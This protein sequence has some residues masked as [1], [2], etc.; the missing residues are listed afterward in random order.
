MTVETTSFAEEYEGTGTK[1]PF[2]Y[3][4]PILAAA[5]LRVIRTSPTGVETTLTLGSNYTVT[6][7]RNQNGGNVL[8]TTVLPVG[9]KIAIQ[10]KMVYT[11]SVDI[12]NQAAY[13]PEVVEEALDRLTMCIQQLSNEMLT[14]LPSYSLELPTY[15]NND[16]A[17]AAG[18]LDGQLYKTSEGRVMVKFTPSVPTVS[19]AITPTTASLISGESMQLSATVLGTTNQAVT[20][21]VNGYDGGSSAVGTIT[22]EG[23]SVTYLSPAARSGT[24]TI[25]VTSDED[26][27][28]SASCPVTVVAVPVVSVGLTPGSVTM[29][30]NG[31]QD[32]TASVAGLTD[33]STVWKV[34]GVTDGDVTTG[35][36]TGTGLTREYTAPAT[37]GVHLIVVSSAVDTSKS[38]S[39]QVTVEEAEVVGPTSF[40]GF[41]SLATGGAGNATVHVTNLNSSGTGSFAAACASGN[42]IIV[43]D[44]GGTIALTSEP[45]IKSNTTVDGSTAPGAGITFTGRGIAI[46]QG[47]NNIILKSF[48]HRGGYNG[49][50]EED[51]ITIME[52][53]YNIVLDHLSLS[54]SYDENIGIWD[55]N[56]NITVQNCIVGDGHAS[57][58]RY[59]S[60]CSNYNQRVTYYHNLFHNVYYRSPAIGYDVSDTVAAPSVTAD[61]VNNVVWAYETRGTTVYHGGKA[62]V[63]GNYY[64][65]ENHPAESNRAVNV[66]TLGQ[67]YSTG[68]Y[69]LDGSGTSGNA[70]SPFTVEA[71]AQIS[72]S[73]AADALT[74][75]KANAGCR[76]GGLDAF[77]TAI[78]ADVTP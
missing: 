22:G 29:V 15:T 72:A 3:R 77:D 33:T 23:G 71:Y 45:T 46:R 57:G 39:A 52:D 68:N 51:N 24:F 50:G 78:M 34:D 40:Y 42:R 66:E 54:G 36:I 61:V 65:S 62:N 76:T 67:A 69:S 32:F 14:F 4:F 58:E 43:F 17:V 44:V 26:P 75:V 13:L 9:Y 47:A 73:S 18:L 7:A 5:D 1:G 56:R 19:I 28:K 41:G 53:C 63:V 70:G 49:T 64:Y 20:W 2:P 6:G 27:T 10:R 60:L 38:A 30:V 37:D 12:R 74:Y 8:L 16:A 48:R 31:S 59:G 35:T 11:Q 25:Q 21:S 55:T